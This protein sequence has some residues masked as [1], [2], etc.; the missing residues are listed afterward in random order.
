[1]RFARA[2]WTP[3]AAGLA[4]VL[5]LASAGGA[6]AARV[7]DDWRAACVEG[8]WAAETRSRSGR[9]LLRISR[10]AGSKA[11]WHVS[12]LGLDGRLAKNAGIAFWVNGSPAARLSS[13]AE[14]RMLE[15]NYFVADDDALAALFP[16]LRAGRRLAVSYVR[17]Q[18]SRRSLAFSLTGLDAALA[19][20]DLRQGRKGSQQTVSSPG[21]SG[22]R[23]AGDRAPQRLGNA[24]GGAASVLPGAIAKAHAADTECDFPKRQPRLFTESIV[25]G[26]LDAIHVLFLL[27]CFAGPYNM[28][29]RAY[30]HDERYPDDARPEFFATYSDARG[31]FGKADLINADWEPATK[32][33]TAREL[34]RGIGDCGSLIRY[35]WTADGLRLVRY[36]YWEKCDGTHLAD[37][38]PVIYDYDKAAP[39]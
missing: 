36:Q 5:L 18:G 23:L 4:A 15:G 11:A 14:L 29:Y 34:G 20:I 8:A 17:E 9:T 31:W 7:F 27:P 22:R 13:P 21:A 19:W 35:R 1:M 37:D 25:R 16:G 38:W 6:A 26:R 12:L 30:V 28:G 33:I 24:E 32:I 2:P 3:G 39:R 10:R